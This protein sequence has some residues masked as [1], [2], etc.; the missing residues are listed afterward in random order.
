MDPSRR[1]T[2]AAPLSS[3][4]QPHVLMARSPYLGTCFFLVI[5]IVFVSTHAPLRGLAEWIAVLV[6]ALIVT[7]IALYGWWGTIVGRLRLRHG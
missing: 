2:P 4:E 7:V 5:L 1:A 6:V 3:P